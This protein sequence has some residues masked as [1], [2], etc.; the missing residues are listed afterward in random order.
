[1]SYDGR[2]EP[3]EAPAAA[4][5]FMDAM[6]A[7]PAVDGGA[8]VFLLHERVPCLR[9]AER[10]PNFGRCFYLETNTLAVLQKA[11][12][13]EKVVRAWIAS[14]TEHTHETFG[15][16]LGRMRE[17]GEADGRVD[18][19]TQNCLSRGDIASQHRLDPFTKQLLAE[20]RITFEASANGLFEIAGQSCALP[21]F[22][23]CTGQD[24]LECGCRNFRFKTLLAEIAVAR[25][26]RRAS[27]S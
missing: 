3:G 19:V 17:F 26:T 20:L 15:G 5:L 27:F 13:F 23:T 4:D 11:D 18:V 21:F 24:P 22:I 6:V 7:M 2:V 25:M 10:S 8:D 1:M 9:W 12:D 16:N 14:R